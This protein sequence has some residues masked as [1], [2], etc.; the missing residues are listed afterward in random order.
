M[1]QRQALT[2]IHLTALL[3]GLTGVFGHMIQA[4][5]FAITSGRA[6]FAV[7]TLMVFA[8]SQGRSLLAGLDPRRVLALTVSGALLASH[9]V[10]FFVAVKIGGVAVAT[11]GFA[12]VPAFT[13]LLERLVYRD[14]IGAA[15]WW[16]LALVSFGLV[17]VAPAFDLAD[18][19][20]VGVLW[21][22]LSG[23]SFAVLA[24]VNRW[25]AGN[26]DSI[27][28][29]CWQN[30]VVLALTLPFGLAGLAGLQ[31]PDWFALAALGIFCTGLAHYLFVSSLS[32]L[33]ARTAGMVIALEPVY[34]ILAAWLL[35]GDRPTLRML[36]GAGCILGAT[37]ATTLRRRRAAAG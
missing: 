4:E 13:V 29:A 16:L 37:V 22:V 15:E 17:L 24:L 30:G 8:R 36:L 3:F 20:T 27:Q 5:P 35:F 33:N 14:R 11:L 26:L 7:L 19:G 12:S 23:F 31:A 9:W 6:A 25:T 10:T 2:A 32:R 21:G 1:Q 28:V 18:T 34:A